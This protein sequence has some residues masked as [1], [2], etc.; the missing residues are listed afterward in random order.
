MKARMQATLWSGI[1]AGIVV[2]WPLGVHGQA[3]LSGKMENNRRDLNKA[4][5]AAAPKDNPGV[6]TTGG[7]L[8]EVVV[9]G[10][11]GKPVPEDRK[12]AILQFFSEHGREGLKERT[13]WCDSS[14]VATWEAPAAINEDGSFSQDTVITGM[15]ANNGRRETRKKGQLPPTP[16]Q[17]ADGPPQPARDDATLAKVLRL[18]GGYDRIDTTL[19]V[20]V[21]VA[22]PASDDDAN[23]VFRVGALADKLLAKDTPLPEIAKQVRAAYPKVVLDFIPK[24]RPPLADITTLLG[25]PDGKAPGTKGVEYWNKYG[26]LHLG[27]SEGKVVAARAAPQGGDETVNKPMETSDSKTTRLPSFTGG[28]AGTNPVR[29][30]NPNDFA[31]STGLRLGAGG[32]DFD[33]PANGVQTVYVPNGRYDIYFVYSDKPDALF[34]GDSFTLNDNGVEIQIVKVVNGNYGIRQVK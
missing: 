14:N 4:Q 1:V 9:N 23:A 2:T 27:V 21:T 26:W 17:H 30:R 28:L 18:F 3:V 22:T 7:H 15:N 31:V 16:Q 5:I 11:D 10:P 34:Q 8:E 24:N 13:V 29:V 25:A 12:R 33:V 20:A 6:T 19:T 32:K